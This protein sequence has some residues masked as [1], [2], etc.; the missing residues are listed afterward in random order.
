MQ[1]CY[2]VPVNRHVYSSGE[3]FQLVGKAQVFRET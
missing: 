1:A 2:D 3:R